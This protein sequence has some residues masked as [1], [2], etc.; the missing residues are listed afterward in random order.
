[1]ERKKFQRISR[2]IHLTSSGIEGDELVRSQVISELP[3]V[4]SATPEAGGISDAL[5]RE[6]QFSPKSV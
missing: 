3:P 5:R 6:I 2:Y 1:M 4:E